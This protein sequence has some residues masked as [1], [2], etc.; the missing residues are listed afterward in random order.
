MNGD[1]DK[2]TFKLEDFPFVFHTVEGCRQMLRSGGVHIL[3]EVAPDGVN[4]LMEAKINALDDEGYAQ[5]LRYHYYI[6]EKPEL[7]GMSNHLLFIGEK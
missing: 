4:E 1:Y 7:L 5:Y 3:K 2:D 6:C